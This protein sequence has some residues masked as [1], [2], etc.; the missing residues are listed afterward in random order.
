MITY[1]SLAIFFFFNSFLM[2]CIKT[3]NYESFNGFTQGTTYHIIFENPK[4]FNAIELK[5][6]VEKILF[7]FDMSL[8][9]YNKSSVISRINRN[10]DVIPDTFFIDVFNKSKTISMMTGGAFDITVGPLVNA[11]GFERKQ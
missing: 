9:V 8:S 7:D 1:R 11:W 2:S 6:A 5:T 10:E 4:K 3:Q